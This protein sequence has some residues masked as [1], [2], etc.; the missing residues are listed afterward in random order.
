MNLQNIFFAHNQLNYTQHSSLYLANVVQLQSDKKQS[1]DYLK[2]NYNVT[3]KAIS[4]TS[5]GSDHTMEQDINEM[6]VRGEIM[7]ISQ[8]MAVVHCFCLTPHLLNLISE[9]FSTK[10]QIKVTDVRNQHYQLTGSYLKYLQTNVERLVKSMENVY[11][12]FL[13]SEKVDNIFLKQY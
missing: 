6:K 2:D 1:W 4:F 12:Y 3:K 5:V 9:E 10:F 11:I 8:N 13:D 7:E